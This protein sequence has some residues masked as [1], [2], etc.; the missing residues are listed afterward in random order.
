MRDLDPFQAKSTRHEMTCCFHTEMNRFRRYIGRFLGGILFFCCCR[1]SFRWVGCQEAGALRQQAGNL[2]SW[3]P[4]AFPEQ[5]IRKA[6]RL[7]VCAQYHIDTITAAA[8]MS[9]ILA[10][11]LH[12]NL[13]DPTA[14]RSVPRCC[15]PGFWY[16][17]STSSSPARW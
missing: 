10:H 7:Q 4:E 16:S 14:V 2:Q 8:A 9:P 11:S 13:P 1:L 17:S 15:V 3:Y 5:D 6:A 12:S